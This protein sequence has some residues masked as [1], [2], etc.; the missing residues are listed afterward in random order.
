MGCHAS[1]GDPGRGAVA[2]VGYNPAL[3]RCDDR[4]HARS[5]PKKAHRRR[6]R[7]RGPR[8]FSTA[9]ST[10]GSTG[11]AFSTA[12]RASPSAGSARRRC[13]PRSAPTSPPPSRCRE[14][15]RASSPTRAEFPS[16]R[17][18]AAPVRGYLRASPA[19][20]GAGRRLADGARRPREPRPEPAHRGHRAPPRGRQLHRLRARRAV[21][22]RRLSRATRTRR[23]SCSAGSTRRRPARTCSPRRRYLKTRAGRQRQGRRG[24]LLLGRRH[25][26]LPRHPGARSRRRRARSTGPRRPAPASR[27]SRRRCC[28]CSPTTT[29]S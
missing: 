2:R 23:A 7:T 26:Q 9:T 12:R 14:T 29:T 24:R 8:A 13:S 4:H 6:L 5:R 20:A 21:P 16:P 15:I 27:R 19:A 1:T 25:G 18:L 17:G 22:A 11:A 28:S 3:A 10:A